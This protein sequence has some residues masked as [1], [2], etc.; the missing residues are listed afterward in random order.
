M[1]LGLINIGSLTAFNDVVS[2]S[3]SALY[4]SY[5]LVESLLLWRRCTGKIRS[6]HPHT[7]PELHN[8]E[9]SETSP[10]IW[11]PFHIPG[12]CGVANNIV[13]VGFGVIILFFS[14]WPPATPVTPATMNFSVLMTGFIVLFA[15]GYYLVW[16]RHHFKG[17]IIEIM[18][19]SE[20]SSTDDAG[21][22]DGGKVLSS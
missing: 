8:V 2:L 17:P 13:S 18:P 20:A 1:V 10:L 21:R 14:F 9:D 22:D 3:V 15:S 19:Y 6:P 11:G 7:H 12:I 5:I 4:T 16:A